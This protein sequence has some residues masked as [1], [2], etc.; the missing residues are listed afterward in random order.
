[1]EAGCNENDASEGQLVRQE[2]LVTGQ[3][4]EKA[5]GR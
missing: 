2:N 3:E 5:W 4:H 1:M